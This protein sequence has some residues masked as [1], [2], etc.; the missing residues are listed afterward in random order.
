MGSL[1]NVDLGVSYV[2]LGGGG[3]VGPSVNVDMCVSPSVGADSLVNMDLCVSYV[4]LSECRLVGPL[5][6]VDLGVS[7]VSFSGCGL[8]G[9]AVNVDLC[10]LCLPQWMRTCGSCF[11]L[12]GCGLVGPSYVFL[13]WVWTCRST[14]T[15]SVGA[16]L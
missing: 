8:V 7:Y 2:S 9:P 11:I 3:L 6:N 12:S 13:K 15:P 5:V 14:G 4:S 1:V 10:V 16:D